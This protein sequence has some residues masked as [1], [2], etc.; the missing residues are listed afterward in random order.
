MVNALKRFI[1]LRG[2]CKSILSDHGT[3]FIGAIGQIEDFQLLKSA[4]EAEGIEWSLN[5]VGASHFGGSFERKIG[6]V[7][8]VL[9]ASLRK[10]V[11][12][13]RRDDLY[14]LLQEA[15]SVVNSTPLYAVAD[16][17]DEP[18]PLT[19]S[20]L[21]TLRSPADE[22][23]ARGAYVEADVMA[24]G[25]RRW[26]RVQYLAD[27]FWKLWRS[28][29]LQEL[30]ARRKWC[31]ET[32]NLRKGDLILLREKNLPRRDWRMG[33]VKEPIEGADGLVR[34]VIITILNSKGKRRDTERA[35]VDLVLLHRPA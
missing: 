10:H 7:R 4:A 15:A 14:T 16:D 20:M 13:L 22:E 32:N 1:A 11:G 34:K 27:E 6:S 17:A 8:R 29:Y 12:R 19:P 30:T 31:R 33:L 24:Y 26:R 3:N 2:R 35:V 28:H 25:Q 5:P 23:G 21:L 9:E 18:L